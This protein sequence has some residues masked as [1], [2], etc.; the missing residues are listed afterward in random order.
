VRDAQDH[1]T[2]RGYPQQTGAVSHSSPAIRD[3]ALGE[4]E[5]MLLAANSAEQ[6]YPRALRQKLQV[7][8]IRMKTAFKILPCLWTAKDDFPQYRL[9]KLAGDQITLYSSH[10]LRCI[11]WVLPDCCGAAR[12]SGWRQ[13]MQPKRMNSCG[14]CGAAK[15][16]R[17]GARQ[18]TPKEKSPRPGSGGSVTENVLWSCRN[19]WRSGE[20]P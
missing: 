5:L 6:I 20:P 8:R 9:R 4:L 13:V 11:N 18:R 1:R 16:P 2:T 14:R 17:G 3:T 15:K 7:V 10:F 19:I 12:L